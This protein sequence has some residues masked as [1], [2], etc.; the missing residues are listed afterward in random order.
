MSKQSWRDLDWGMSLMARDDLLVRIISFRKARVP[1]VRKVRVLRSAWE[2]L[3]AAQQ[4]VLRA[5]REAG[6]SELNLPKRAGRSLQIL[7]DKRV[8]QADFK[9]CT[10]S[11]EW[12]SMPKEA[13]DAEDTE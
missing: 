6:D 8:I 2:K 13:K 1:P 10:D 11:A 3:S 7:V 5:I 4:K 12:I 9:P